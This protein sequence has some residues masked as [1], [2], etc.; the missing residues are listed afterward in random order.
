MLFS[1]PL[2][3]LWALINQPAAGAFLL[4]LSAVFLFFYPFVPL[5]SRF[6]SGLWLVYLATRLSEELVKWTQTRHLSPRELLE[7]GNFRTIVVPLSPEE[8]A[9]RLPSIL[10]SPLWRSKVYKERTR[11]YF[12]AQGLIPVQLLRLLLYGGILIALLGFLF[13]P[14]T[15]RAEQYLL[16]PGDTFNFERTGVSFCLDEIYPDKLGGK[17]AFLAE[18]KLIKS[19][20]LAPGRPL[21]LGLIM[22]IPVGKS[23]ALNVKVLNEEVLIL[24]PGGKEFSGELTVPFFMP[25]DEKYVFF[26]ARHLILRLILIPGSD[27]HF[28]LEVFREGAEKAELKKKI[29]GAEVLE[30]GGAK[31]EIIPTASLQ[32][33]LS[34]TVSLWLITFGLI[35]A[36]GTLLFWSVFP[37]GKVFGFIQKEEKVRINW[38]QEDSFEISC[39]E[40]VLK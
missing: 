3:F 19:G 14:L 1:D 25:N 21:I 30:I 6:L 20:S 8:L 17:G 28:L 35:V 7:K 16:T 22:A 13:A 5:I 23:P 33:K 26:P 11:Y 40:R 10:A 38:A 15:D 18:N 9:A 39:F 12:E 4:V 34:R 31:V 32:I 24:H 37:A 29:T 36:A 27:G 2:R